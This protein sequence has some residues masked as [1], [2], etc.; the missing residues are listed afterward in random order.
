MNTLLRM[1]MQKIAQSAQLS[2]SAS[3]VM[4]RW[5]SQPS[6]KK[7]AYYNDH[8]IVRWSAKKLK[9]CSRI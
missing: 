6:Y 9:S 3:G 4:V 2:A 7:E 8:R 1:V 5:V